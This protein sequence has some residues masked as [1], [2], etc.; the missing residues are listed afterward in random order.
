[1]TGLGDDKDSKRGMTAAPAGR[2]GGL[3]EAGEAWAGGR[4]EG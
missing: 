3:R 1:M 4:I 2:L